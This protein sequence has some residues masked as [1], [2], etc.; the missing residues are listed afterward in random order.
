MKP[1]EGPPGRRSATTPAAVLGCVLFVAAV[2]FATVQAGFADVCYCAP[3]SYSGF[4]Q[5][6]TTSSVPE[7]GCGVDHCLVNYT[8]C[9]PSGCQSDGVDCIHLP[10]NPCSSLLCNSK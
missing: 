3:C 8:I 1:K 7:Q 5:S 4:G 2:V 6:K 10:S 9:T